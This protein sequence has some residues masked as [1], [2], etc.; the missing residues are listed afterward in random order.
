MPDE[1]DK[2]HSQ[3]LER[4]LATILSADVAE[5]SRLMGEDEEQA[6]RV[7]R[8]HKQVFESVVAEH[9]GRIFNTAGDAILAEFT[10][11]VEAV[12]CATDIQAALRTRNDQLPLSR[13]V[14]FRIGINLGDVMLHGQDLL[15]DGVN[16]AARLQTAAQPGGICISGSVYD[17]IRNK[18]S[19]SFQSLGE[20]SFKNIQ[21]PVRTFSITEAEGCGALPSAKPQSERRFSGR[22]TWVV[23]AGLGVLGAAGVGNLLLRKTTPKLI[24]KGTIVLTDFTNTTSDPVFD[25]T[26]RQGLSAQLVQS[27]FL[28]LISDERIAQT[29]ALMRQS[30]DARRT[31]ELTR[32]ICQRTA[33]AATIEGSI[34]SLGS[35]YV[36]GLNAVNCHTGDL[37][38]QEQVTANGKEQVLT[39]LGDAST[40]LRR[41]LG[42]SLA[43][44]QKYDSRPQN[45]TTPSLEA[46]QAYSLGYQAFIVGDDSA[47]AIPFFLRAVSLDPN[48]AMAYAL[49]GTSYD[50]LGEH[51]GAAEN[52]RKAYELRGRT[53]E[54]EKL[55]ISSF[56]EQVVTGNLKAARTANELWAQTY[57]RDE[58]PLYNLTVINWNLGE[59]GKALTAAQAELRLNPAS[60]AAY[61]DLVVTYRFLNRL[62]EAR[63]TAQEARAHNLSGPMIH[64]MLYQLDF[65][66]HDAAGM[67]REAAGLMGKP[68]YDV[69]ILYQ[70][71]NTAAFGGEFAKARQLM[72]YAVHTAQQAD[73]NE[74]A[75][76]H[77]AD[78]AI[79]EAWVG[80]LALAKEKARSALALG[81]SKEIEAVS[82]IALGLGGDSMQAERLAGDL[83]KRFAED[84]IVQSQYLP[85]IHAAA[86]LRNGEPGKA[87]GA[88]AA[89]TPYELGLWHLY[90]AYLRGEAFL[91]AKQG[92][93]AEVEF[94]KI[95][96]HPG[97]IVNEPIGA[98]AHLGL[99]RAYAL[100]G[101][102][103]KAK[104]A[105]QDFLS[106]WK[107]AD[108]DIPILQQS[109]AEYAKLK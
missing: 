8:G 82:A 77:W 106:L 47:G 30:K 21:Q 43:S 60:G 70:E 90:T 94:R 53:S 16:V 92:A 35:Q 67:E 2:S 3:F 61:E 65:L 9:R 7:F 33:S 40:K 85:M 58:G 96:D 38:A 18:L 78:A 34:S 23:G 69:F 29:L 73:E 79:R 15:G 25:G 41:K 14:K 39:A 75:A 68:G 97:V 37:L 49:M 51:A 31:K 107:N 6:L 74:M 12:R 93:P 10:S 52:A 59:Y 44:V 89:A 5:F 109:K 26:L 36:V 48:F 66:Q 87:L 83:G 98:L 104:T 72:R 42:E 103:T 32:E 4:K 50:R 99:G 84:T 62:D 91:A 105:Y 54:Q 55:S 20:M 27:P 56:Y 76:A 80:N 71:S 24:E 102:S 1:L 11:A 81:N 46:L 22:R 57:P 19:L 28:N 100:A 88:L 101:D 95:L 13:Q 63:A 17:Q 86:R 108:P 45:V 64:L